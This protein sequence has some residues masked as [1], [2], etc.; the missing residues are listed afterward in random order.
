M[1]G[2]PIGL[3]AL[4]FR[5]ERQCLLCYSHSSAK[6]LMRDHRRPFFQGC[7]LYK[8]TI[9]CNLRDELNGS[10]NCWVPLKIRPI[11]L[12]YFTCIFSHNRTFGLNLL[13]ILWALLQTWICLRIF[14]SGVFSAACLWIFSCYF[15]ISWE[16]KQ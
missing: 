4:T 5:K 9:L 13:N 11:L 15:S 10:S 8:Q 6:T 14:F 16:L 1:F 12:R 2:K 7:R 3:M